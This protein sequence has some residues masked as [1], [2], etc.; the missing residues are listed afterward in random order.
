MHNMT[1]ATIAI[2]LFLVMDPLGNIPIFLSALNNV[3]PKKRPWVILRECAIAFIIL[4]L[5][6]F[7]GKGIL[8]SLQISQPALSISGG[9]IL[10]L[11]ALKMIFPGPDEAIREHQ[12]MEPFIV[13]LAIPLVAGPSAMATILIFTSHPGTSPWLVLSSLTIATIASTVI[14]LLSVP[15]R[16]ILGQK[17]LIAIERLMG[18]ILT[19]LSV[20]MFLTGLEQFFH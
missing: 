8:N 3:Q 17:G 15:L 2:T 6:V 16:A 12:V 4:I 13:P 19:T 20:Q 9:I 14:L 18:M 1:L 5:F 7:F 10:F 11:I